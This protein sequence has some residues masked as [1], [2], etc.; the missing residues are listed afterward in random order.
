MSAVRNEQGDFLLSIRVSQA[1]GLIP[2]GRFGKLE[3]RLRNPRLLHFASRHVLPCQPTSGA[4]SGLD[5]EQKIAT[6]MVEPSE[7]QSMLARQKSSDA[8]D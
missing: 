2:F 8:K 3:A 6:T 4:L 7:C 5:R 1:I